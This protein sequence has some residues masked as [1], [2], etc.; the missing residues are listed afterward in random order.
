MQASFYIDPSVCQC[1]QTRFEVSNRAGLP[2]LTDEDIVYPDGKA[3]SYCE[4][5]QCYGSNLG[6]VNG[7]SDWSFPGLLSLFKYMMGYCIIIGC[8]YLIR[9]Y[10]S[11]L[12]PLWLYS[13]LNPVRF[14]RFLILYTVGSTTWMGDQ[15]VARQLPTHRTTQTQNKRTQTSMPRVGFEPMTPVFE[16]A[17]FSYTRTY[18]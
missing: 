13:P 11:Y 3:L 9:I 17:H 5:N 10:L 2:T 1:I 15:H 18:A 8:D 6:Q 14:F 12:F 16:L 4:F 7:H